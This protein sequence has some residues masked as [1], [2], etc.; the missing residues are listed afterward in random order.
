MGNGDFHDLIPVPM[1]PSAQVFTGLIFLTGITALK[2][3]SNPALMATTL[4]TSSIL[5][6]HFLTTWRS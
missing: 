3:F 2:K 5:R 1:T 6:P 4:K